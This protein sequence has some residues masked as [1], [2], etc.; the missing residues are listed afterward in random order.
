MNATYSSL[1]AHNPTYSSWVVDLAAL[2]ATSTAFLSSFASSAPLS[3]APALSTTLETTSNTSTPSPSFKSRRIS[4]GVL[5]GVIVGTVAVL[6]LVGL[7][8]CLLF[9]RKTKK[10]REKGDFENV[11]NRDASDKYLVTENA[12]QKGQHLAPIEMANTET[13]LS[14]VEGSTPLYEMK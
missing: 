5:G 1:I 6:A 7:S 9:K 14:E 4:G 11:N 13:Q 2:T 3:T 8:L 10:R 12:Q